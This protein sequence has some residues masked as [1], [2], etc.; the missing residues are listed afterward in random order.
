M[1]TSYVVKG[2]NIRK[3]LKKFELNVQKLKI[4]K[5]FA[6]A[7]IGENGAGKTTLL[8]IISGIRLDYN[9]QI[10]Y[11]DKYNDKD[12]EKNPEVKS[13]IGYTGPGRYYLPQWTV[14]DIEEISKLLFEDFSSEKFHMLCDEL[15][16]FPEG[17][18]N[19]SKKSSDLS[20][21]TKMKLMLAGVMARNTDLLILDEPASPLDP[22]M[23]DKLCQM[24]G[25]YIENGNGEKSVFFSTH[26]ISDMENITDYAIIMEHGNIVEAGFVEDLK[27]KYI[28]VKGDAC[29]VEAAKQILYTI[30]TNSYGFEGICLAKDLDKLAGMKVTKEI[31]SLY[32]ISVA[33]MKNNTKLVMR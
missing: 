7:L 23:R 24:I 26:N 6:T 32:Q 21:G 5:G 25:E 14:S 18:F 29:D 31:P 16:I 28:L 19:G 30:S 8:N 27:E 13:R 12:R 4:P 2:E 3:K 17:G 9:G 15:A 22:L 33:V 11:F 20:D 1:E 10:T